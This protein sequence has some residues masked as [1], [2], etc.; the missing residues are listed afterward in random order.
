MNRN[1][2]LTSFR[3]PLEF[4]ALDG[5]IERLEPASD[6][7]SF[8]PVRGRPELGLVCVAVLYR[9]ESTLA[10]RWV[11]CRYR[12]DRQAAAESG[13]EWEREESPRELTALLAMAACRKY[14]IEPPAAL[15]G[16]MPEIPALPVE[17]TT[18]LARARQ[19]HAPTV[20]TLSR[21]AWA[22]LE[23]T[24]SLKALDLASAKSQ[25]AIAMAANAG[26]AGSRQVRDAF[27]TM[28]AVGFI[29]WRRGAGCW[30][31]AAGTVALKQRG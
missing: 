14:G 17:P 19:K 5:A 18:T 20:D 15:Q 13:Q 30:I 24:R 6:A 3:R 26:N 22:L 9:C 7:L 21:T 25:D 11:L 31:T 16:Q 4:V 10:P 1:T 23:A 2:P 12:S 29:E 27:G 8:G 28:K